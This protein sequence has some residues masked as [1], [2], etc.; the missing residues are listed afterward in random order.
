MHGVPVRGGGR[1]PRGVS[2]IRREMLRELIVAIV[3]SPSVLSFTRAQ[4]ELLSSGPVITAGT[5][6]EFRAVFVYGLKRTSDP[7]LA[8]ITSPSGDICDVYLERC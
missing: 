6:N 5:I 2:Y 4:G 8:I 1:R 7:S 3:L